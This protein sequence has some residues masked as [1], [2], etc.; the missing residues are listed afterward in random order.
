MVNLR[1]RVLRHA[2]H[3]FNMYFYKLNTCLDD[4]VVVLI[5]NVMNIMFYA[6][7]YFGFK[8]KLSYMLLKLKICIFKFNFVTIKRKYLIF[9]MLT[10]TTKVYINDCKMKTNWNFANLVLGGLVNC[11]NKKHEN[12]HQT[13]IIRLLNW[14]KVFSKPHH[15]R[16]AFHVIFLELLCPLLW[17]VCSWSCCQ[18]PHFARASCLSFLI[19][20]ILIHKLLHSFI[21][22][23]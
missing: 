12:H 3:L 18:C 20:S 1:T 4:F 16:S 7:I 5:T 13:L 14:V 6:K 21:I 17:L 10:I 9:I 2:N 8:P 19:S 11:N 15:H 22:Y 23:E